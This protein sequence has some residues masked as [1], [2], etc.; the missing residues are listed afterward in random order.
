MK[1]INMNFFLAVAS[2]FLNFATWSGRASRS[3]FWYFQ[4]LMLICYIPIYVFDREV[5]ATTLF[6]FI[7][8]FML[9][10]ISVTVRR[11]HDTNR[12][13]WWYWIIMV[14]VIGVLIFYGLMCWPGDANRNDYGENP[15]M[16]EW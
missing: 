1:D 10:N 13:G 3:E 7:L 11:L 4:L 5:G 14:P 8:I 15:L 12:S 6:A 2:A 9:P 16:R